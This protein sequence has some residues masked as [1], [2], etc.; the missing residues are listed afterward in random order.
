MQ[1]KIVTNAKKFVKSMQDFVGLI[2]II[3]FI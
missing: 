1:K 3:L 2:V